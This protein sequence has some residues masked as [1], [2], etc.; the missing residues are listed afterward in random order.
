MSGRDIAGSYPALSVFLA[1]RLG[2]LVGLGIQWLLV[3]LRSMFGS[4]KTWAHFGNMAYILR[5]NLGTA[6]CN[7][8]IYQS[9]HYRAPGSQNFCFGSCAGIPH[10]VAQA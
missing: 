9:V 3:H 5:K 10:T 8:S 7:Q 6:F 2:I 1:S 4:H